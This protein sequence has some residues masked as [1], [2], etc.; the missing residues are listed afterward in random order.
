ML[1]RENASG[2]GRGA[3]RASGAGRSGV[4]AVRA[5]NPGN[6]PDLGGAGLAMR[7]LARPDAAGLSVAGGLGK[8]TQSVLLRCSRS[9]AAF[10]GLGTRESGS[11]GQ[12]SSSG[13]PLE[14][15]GQPRDSPSRSYACSVCV[16]QN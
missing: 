9:L 3:S 7:S 2:A 13:L 15:S 11:L 10:L 4:G 5:A 14:G 12:V 16:L 1:R 8:P 6:S